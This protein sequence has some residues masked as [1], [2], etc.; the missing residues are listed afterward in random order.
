[1]AIENKVSGT[2]YVSFVV[3]EEGKVVMPKIERG[4]GFGMDEMLL[5][6]VN[7]IPDFTP[8]EQNGRKVKIRMMLPVKFVLSN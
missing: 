1:M 7:T 4:L 3:N 8:A 5:K 6:V 2:M